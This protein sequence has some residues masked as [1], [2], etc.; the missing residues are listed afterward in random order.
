VRWSFPGEDAGSVHIRRY[1]RDCVNRAELVGEQ[2]GPA[3]QTVFRQT[4]L[5]QNGHCLGSDPGHWPERTDAR[6]GSGKARAR[7]VSPCR[8][9]TPVWGQ[10]PDNVRW[11]PVRALAASPSRE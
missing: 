3:A 9:K 8:P 7:G 1:G 10:T 6:S 5:A 2:R 4:L 11:G